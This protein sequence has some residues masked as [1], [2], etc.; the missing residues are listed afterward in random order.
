M[1]AFWLIVLGMLVFPILAFL[2]V[3]ISPHLLG[4][5]SA[6]FS[7]DAFRNALSGQMKQA[8][9]NSLMVG[10]GAAVSATVAGAFVAWVVVRTNAPGRS[11]WTGSMFAL[12]LAPSYMIAMGWE[13]LLEPLGVLQTLGYQGTALQHVIY[14]P[15][16]VTLVLAVKG[17][18]FAYLAFSSALRGLGAQYEAAVRVHGGGSVAAMRMAISLVSPAVWASLAIVFAEAISDFGVADTL[19]YN[20]HFPVATYQLYN[21]V[22]SFPVDFP[23]AA[24]VGWLLLGMAAMALT[25]QGWALRGRSFRV[26]SARNAAVRR[27][28]LRPGPKVA[29]VA[30]M[31]LI[32]FVG[33]G[34]PAIGAVSASLL[35][36]VGSLATNHSLTLSNYQRALT[37]PALIGP[38]LYSAQLAAITACAVLV[39]ALVA[40]R[41]LSS[42]GRA[43]S[44]RVLDLLLIT[45]VALPGIVFA[46]GYIFTYNLPLMNRLGINLYETTTLLVVA[47][48]ATA[49]PGTTRVLVGAV[50]QV[51]D[52]VGH[53]ARVHGFRAATA[54]LRAVL[55]LLARP[56]VSAWVLT[57]TG[58]LLELP[59]S[60]LLYPPGKPPLAIGIETALS[61]YDFSG[62]TAME[63]LAI[64]FALAVVGVVWGLYHLLAPAGWQRLGRAD[65]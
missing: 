4:F 17:I 16:G 64:L 56:L 13:R 34:I 21:A 30:V 3:A 14:G 23:T 8:L 29:V 55:P 5:G 35:A 43:M 45:A 22:D 51:P 62:G 28:H 27:T 49:M 41:L 26:L 53:A 38:L 20:A 12:L 61:K 39:F 58:T 7:L 37:N 42:H 54:W 50:A 6:W 36:G 46:V 1:I 10:T 2:T 33:L 65:A 19:A 57:F 63:V 60:Q 32:E 9:G 52:S 40:A 15:V 47:Y 44:S 31:L 25:A 59:V 48:I 11:M 24:A 18:P